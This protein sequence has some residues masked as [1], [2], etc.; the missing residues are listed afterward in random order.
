MTL[1]GLGVNYGWKLNEMVQ[2]TSSANSCYVKCVA[3]DKLTN[4]TKMIDK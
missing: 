1:C 3:T 2:H 4:V